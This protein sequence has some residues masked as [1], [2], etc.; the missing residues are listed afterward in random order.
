MSASARRGRGKRRKKADA[1]M[2]IG[3]IG[4][5]F[6][7]LDRDMRA[8]FAEF[9]REDSGGGGGGGD[10]ERE[11]VECNESDVP[12][13]DPTKNEE[14]FEQQ[15][16][17]ENKAA[18]RAVV[19]SD[20][21]LRYAYERQG[22]A[23]VVA[24]MSILNI[25]VTAYLTNREKPPFTVFRP[26]LLDLVRYTDLGVQF[27]TEV[28]GA[29]AILSCAE[30]TCCILIFEKGRIV[31]SG[32][33]NERDVLFAVRRVLQEIRRAVAP[34][35]PEYK[36]LR[37]MEF[38][39]SNIVGQACFPMSIDVEKMLEKEADVSDSPIAN[40]V[41]VSPPVLSDAGLNRKNQ[42]RRAGSTL[43]H[44][45]GY[46]LVIGTKTRQELITAL[47]FVMTIVERY[48][49]G[50]AETTFSVD[51]LHRYY[52]SLRHTYHES[53]K[54][55]DSFVVVRKDSTRGTVEEW[56]KTMKIKEKLDYYLQLSKNALTRGVISAKRTKTLPKA[57]A[58][59]ALPAA[60][61]AA[62]AQ[63]SRALIV[64]KHREQD[65]ATEEQRALV[66]RN[67]NQLSKL[68]RA[69]ISSDL[70]RHTMRRASAVKD[71][72]NVL[73][74]VEKAKQVFTHGPLQTVKSSKP[75]KIQM[76]ST[77]QARHLYK[78]E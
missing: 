77:E 2:K 41:K 40:S 19:V 33:H 21:K 76:M 44:R 54:S 61:A 59:R 24:N 30:P 43:V 75:K 57:A 31:C 28:F 14:Y 6:A 47:A 49:V 51:E 38:S 36:N 9:G 62:D 5:A 70:T 17:R 56:C 34:H 1:G 37:A 3:D 46:L 67:Q 13:L 58:P 45:S 74:Q 73:A 22:T 16:E 7:L 39:V 69:Q 66:N 63:Q 78:G 18:E 60:A 20:A 68:Q 52:A 25:V 48:V 55:P 42:Q 50:S 71:V 29:A 4:E 11:D 72:R 53:L 26:T 32:C 65:N 10:G 35:K 27:N 12:V 8:E 23:P 64:S 15:A